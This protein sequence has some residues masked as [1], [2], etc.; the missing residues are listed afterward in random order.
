M[1]YS[2]LYSCC[3]RNTGGLAQG[4]CPLSIA[5]FLEVLTYPLGII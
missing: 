3:R 5:S 1:L 2:T 4:N